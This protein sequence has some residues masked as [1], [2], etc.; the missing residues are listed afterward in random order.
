MSDYLKQL[1]N[2]PVW[3]KVIA[4]AIFAIIIAA[5]AEIRFKWL[6]HLTARWTI[7]L[8]MTNHAISYQTGIG[9]PLKCHIEVRN[10]SAKAVE[11]AIVK[12]IPKK[13]I[14]KSFPPEVMQ[15]RF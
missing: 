10:D 12:Y 15:V 3:S 4:S 6:K 13:M 14:L 11:V 2:D 1:W 8:T 5:L 9:F 7:K